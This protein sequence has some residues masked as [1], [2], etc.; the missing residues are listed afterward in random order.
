MQDD[1]FLGVHA[2]FTVEPTGIAGVLWKLQLDVDRWTVGVHVFVIFSKWDD[3]DHIELSRFPVR[4]VDVVPSEAMSSPTAEHGDALF[5]RSPGKIELVLRETPVT[6]VLLSLYGGAR[7]IAAL[8]CARPEDPPPPP[9]PPAPRLPIPMPPPG[10]PD[11]H[12]HVD[13]RDAVIAGA[14]DFASTEREKSANNNH[15]RVTSLIV[16][17]VVAVATLVAVIAGG[18]VRR[19]RRLRQTW[20]AKRQARRRMRVQDEASGALDLVPTSGDRRVKLLFE[21]EDGVEVAAHVDL[22][23]VDSVAELHEQVVQTYE[24]AGVHTRFGDVLALHYR[25]ATGKTVPVTADVSLADVVAAGVLRLSRDSKA[26]RTRRTYARIAPPVEPDVAARCARL[27]ADD[28]DDDDDDADTFASI[29]QSRE[30]GPGTI[31][32]RSSLADQVTST[33]RPLLPAPR[34]ACHGS[35]FDDDEENDDED[36]ADLI[37]RRHQGREKARAGARSI[38]L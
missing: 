12:H 7:G 13:D 5:K 9:P 6:T 27:M 10:R 26:R 20:L 35:G 18:A 28:A 11:T 36:D 34:R 30:V 22:Q 33:A 25:D 8:Y 37:Y 16:L 31:A 3:R 15:V 32:L 29:M 17:G 38:A 1:C 23:D 2:R 4:L 19:W 24:S 21:D 14:A